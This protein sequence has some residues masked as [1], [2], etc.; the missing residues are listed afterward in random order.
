MVDPSGYRAGA[1]ELP[2]DA[3]LDRLKIQRAGLAVLICAHVIGKSLTDLR[4]NILVPR[5]RG[6]LEAKVLTAGF[7]L[8]FAVTLDVVERF[9]G[10]KIFH[11]EFLCWQRPN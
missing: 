1:L 6:R 9:D 11:G 10:S 4:R 2:P 3:F 5:D 7:L 8:D